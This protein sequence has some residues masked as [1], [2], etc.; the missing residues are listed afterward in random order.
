TRIT[1][2]TVRALR[3][4]QPRAAVRQRR[5]HCAASPKRPRN[6]PSV[7]APLIPS[8]LLPAPGTVER[9][10][11]PR[12]RLLASQVPVDDV[13]LDSFVTQAC[14]KLFRHGDAPVLASS[15]SHRKRHVVL[16]L[17]LVSG[18]QQP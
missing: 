13:H 11:P 8:R 16:T 7:Y 4:A 10:S 15:A 9:P 2:R 12:R 18:D 17:P 6:P 1:T 3:R 5:A 14:G